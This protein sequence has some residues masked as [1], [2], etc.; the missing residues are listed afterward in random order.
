MG[1]SVRRLEALVGAVLALASVLA[2][3][4]AGQTPNCWQDAA[5][6]YGVDPWLLYAIAKQESGLNPQA[7]G[8]NANGSYDMGLM[9]INSSHLPVLSKFGI[10]EAHLYDPCVSTHVGAWILGGNLRRM[11]NNWVAV[12]AYNAKSHDKRVGYA[13][14][15]YHRLGAVQTK[16]LAIAK[17]ATPEMQK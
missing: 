12:G 8:V 3:A 11:G 7:R 14:K 1:P 2:P 4:W 16:A 15:I 6:R 17:P 10:Q 13:W 9:Q 5:A